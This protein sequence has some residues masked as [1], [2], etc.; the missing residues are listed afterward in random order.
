MNSFVFTNKEGLFKKDEKFS[1]LIDANPKP[2]WRPTKKKQG[3][4]KIKG[5]QI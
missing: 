3:I 4:N 1:I 5:F 2:D